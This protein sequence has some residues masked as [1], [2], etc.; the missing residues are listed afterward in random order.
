MTSAGYQII[1]EPKP[2]FTSSLIVQP[3]IILLA[4]MLVPAP[5]RYLMVA[6]LLFNSWCLGSPTFIK[7]CLYVLAA[8]VIIMLSFVVAGYLMQANVPG[9]QSTAFGPYLRIYIS[10]IYL[11]FLYLIYLRQMPVYELWNYIREQQEQR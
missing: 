9:F 11:T 4:C 7:E 5:F 6:W 2:R 8:F 3:F 10:A 1:D